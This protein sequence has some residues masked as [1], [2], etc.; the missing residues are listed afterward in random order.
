MYRNCWK[1]AISTNH[2]S[3]ETNFHMKNNTSKQ[4]LSL[5][6]S[7]PQNITPSPY[8]YKNTTLPKLAQKRQK[9]KDINASSWNKQ[10]FN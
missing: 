2:L 8:I 1:A 7:S 4:N 10:N 3:N 6:S 5:K 9:N